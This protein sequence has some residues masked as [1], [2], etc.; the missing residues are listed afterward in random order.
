M[1]PI[2]SAHPPTG[3][4]EHQFRCPRMTAFHQE[5]KHD[6]ANEGREAVTAAASPDSSPPSKESAC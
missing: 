5:A 4:P 6:S 2:V 3:S 1:K